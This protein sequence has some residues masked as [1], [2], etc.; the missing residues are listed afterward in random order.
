VGRK[1]WLCGWVERRRK[2]RWVGGWVG[3]GILGNKV[4]FLGDEISPKFDSKNKIS[5]YSKDFPWKKNGPNS[6]YF[7]EKNS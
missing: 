7:K 3:E 6:P 5:S 4:F 2:G 1:K